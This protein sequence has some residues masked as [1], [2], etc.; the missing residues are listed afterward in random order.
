MTSKTRFRVSA[1]TTPGKTT[2][3]MALSTIVRLDFEAGS[4]YNRVPKSKIHSKIRENV[5]KTYGKKKSWQLWFHEKNWEFYNFLRTYEIRIGI[6]T[7]IQSP[8]LTKYLKH[9]RHNLLCDVAGRN[10]AKIRDLKIIFIKIRILN[11]QNY[12]FSSKTI[13]NFTISHIKVSIYDSTC[14][15]WGAW[16]P[17]TSSLALG[18]EV[19]ILGSPLRLTPESGRSPSGLLQSP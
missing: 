15:S 16:V 9:H 8:K 7:L 12:T 14:K 18:G 5:E 4:R 11:F 1:L 13:L 6:H 19:K 2:N 17:P 10:R 3:S